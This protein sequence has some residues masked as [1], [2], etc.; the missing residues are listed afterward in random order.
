L[1]DILGVF[2][3]VHQSIDAIKKPILVAAYQFPKGRRSPL[4]TVSDKPMIVWVHGFLLFLDASG[5]LKVPRR[6]RLREADALTEV[7][8]MMPE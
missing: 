1:D 6:P 4:Q 2:L 8:S 7:L 3:V 5:T